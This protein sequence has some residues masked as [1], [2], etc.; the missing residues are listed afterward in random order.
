[1]AVR[2]QSVEPDRQVAAVA[3]AEALKFISGYTMG[4]GRCVPR[5]HGA[6]RIQSLRTF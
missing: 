2:H 1:V 5:G 4:W 3:D 6:S